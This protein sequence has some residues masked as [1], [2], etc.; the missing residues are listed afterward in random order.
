MTDVS[1]DAGHLL[2]GAVSWMLKVALDWYFAGRALV[3]L[4][5]VWQLRLG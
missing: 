4:N 3:E 2:D 1:H 5:G